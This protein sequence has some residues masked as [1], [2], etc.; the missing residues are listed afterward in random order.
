MLAFSPSMSM[1][2]KLGLGSRLMLLNAPVADPGLIMIL[3][4]NFS[5]CTARQPVLIQL[6][7]CFHTLK[8]SLLTLNSWVWPVTK[9]ST[10]SLRCS[11]AKALTSPHGTTCV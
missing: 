5:A 7:D 4:S 6:F 8:Q 10:S 2:T 11:R 3:S 9:M 1:S